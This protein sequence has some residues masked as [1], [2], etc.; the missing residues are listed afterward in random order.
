M[1]VLITGASSGI[2]R[3]LAIVLSKRYDEMILVGRNKEKLE[4]LRDELK[5]TNVKIISMDISNSDNCIKLFNENPNVDLLVNNAGFGDCGKF[6]ET[7]LHKDLNMINT[8]IVGL[9][10][11]TKLYLKNMKKR[12]SG[13]ILNV[14]SIAG[15]MPGPLM[16]TYYATKNYVVRLSE[17]I[18]LELKKE[19]SQVK[20]SILCPGPVN[21]KFNERANV[22][23]SL[24]GMNSIDLANYTVK[25]LNKFYIVPGL[26]VKLTK[27]ISHIFSS[28]IM[29]KFCYRIQ[30][31]KIVDKN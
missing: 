13:H 25:H 7:D 31:K 30:K 26:G 2:G 5:H 9:H 28:N 14:A 6:Y 15:F 8:N 4:E 1:K 27:F 23:F 29:A 10:I 16:A 21:T 11:L 24:K 12:N 17:A 20:I 3:D 22:I 19:K 18:R